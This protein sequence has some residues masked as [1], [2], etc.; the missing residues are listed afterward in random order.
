[1]PELSIPLSKCCSKCGHPHPLT[2]EFFKPVT[3]HKDG[4][5]SHCRD[6]IRAD[7]RDYMRNR[8]KDPAFLERQ[9]EYDKKRMQ[10]PEVRERKLAQH[11]EREKLPEVRARR[12]IT[13]KAR[14]ER[15]PEIRARKVAYVRELR[16]DPTWQKYYR[17]YNRA[18]FKSERGMAANAKAKAKRR[19]SELSAAGEYTI[20]D[21]KLQLRSQKYKCWWCE[22]PLKGVWHIDHRI[23]LSKG[24]SNWPNN[25]CITCPHCNLSKNNKLPHEFNGR[26]L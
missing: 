16:K 4:Y 7:G 1:M 13:D 22:K 12:R 18:Y 5:S 6:C 25:I 3:H 2:A 19:A 15:K 10:I 17:D 26:L 9:H 23:P 21:V 14:L 20:E 8:R 11:R 24:G